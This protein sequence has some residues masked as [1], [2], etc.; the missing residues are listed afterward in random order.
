MSSTITNP[1]RSSGNIILM[2]IG[3]YSSSLGVALAALPVLALHLALVALI[4]FLTAVTT[5]VDM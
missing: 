3:L 5:A 1:T 4:L 2:F